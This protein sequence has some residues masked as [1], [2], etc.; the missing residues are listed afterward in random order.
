MFLKSLGGFQTPEQEQAEPDVNGPLLGWM[1]KGNWAS[2]RPTLR[3]CKLDSLFLAPH[4]QNQPTPVKTQID[5]GG[6]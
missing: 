4:P 5:K 6:I 2:R 3:T 1:S